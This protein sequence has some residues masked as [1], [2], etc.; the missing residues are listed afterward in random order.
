[1]PAEVV[2]DRERYHSH[3]TETVAA[4]VP[5]R[6][7]YP[8][9]FLTRN[10]TSSQPSFKPSVKK[11]VKGKGKEITY[12]REILCQPRSFGTEK[13]IIDIPQKQWQ[14]TFLAVNKLIGKIMLVSSM[15]EDEIFSEIRSIFR[16]PMQGSKSFT[17]KILQQT[18]G[19]T[20]CLMVPEVSES[21]QWTAAAVAGRNAKTPV[22][23][24]AEDK[25]KVCFSL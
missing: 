19:N 25:L 5:C 6:P 22:C 13:G 10:S 18:G 23:I 2:W 8:S 12:E 9:A 1:M 7:V 20:R 16:K 15:S 4:H 21:Y 14:H 3:P 11:K 17:F 24:L